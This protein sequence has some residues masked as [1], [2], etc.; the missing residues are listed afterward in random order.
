MQLAPPIDH[1]GL[2]MVRIKCHT[3]DRIDHEAP[4][5]KRPFPHD[6]E[7]LEWITDVLQALLTERA[8]TDSPLRVPYSVARRFRRKHLTGVC[9]I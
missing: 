6:G 7:Q 3:A 1:A 8:E 5:R 2:G 4:C 9:M